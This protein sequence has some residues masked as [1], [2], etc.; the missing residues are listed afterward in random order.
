MP[1]TAQYGRIKIEDGSVPFLSNV[2]TFNRGT[3]CCRFALVSMGIRTLLISMRFRIQVAKPK[4]IHPD[5]DPSVAFK[6]Q[7]KIKLFFL[8]LTVDTLTSVFK[9]NKL[10]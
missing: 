9:D 2:V 10:P 6:M 8:L 4:R 7:T 5:P 3:K 1:P